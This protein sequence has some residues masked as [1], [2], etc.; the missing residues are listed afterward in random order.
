MAGDQQ[1]DNDIAEIRAAVRQLCDK[2]GEDYWLQMDRENGYPADFVSELTT[3]GYL[4][5]LIPEQY[6]GAG[7]GVLQASADAAPRDRRLG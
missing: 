6:G 5:V 7:L 4:G 2:F 1:T 3:S